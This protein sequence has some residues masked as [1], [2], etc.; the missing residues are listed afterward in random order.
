MRSTKIKYVAKRVRDATKRENF[1]KNDFVEQSCFY[2]IKLIPQS[3]R[4]TVNDV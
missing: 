4:E 3:N 2:Q 1:N